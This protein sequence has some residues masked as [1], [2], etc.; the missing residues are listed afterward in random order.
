MNRKKERN[1]ANAYGNVQCRKQDLV[2]CDTRDASV[3]KEQQKKV[4]I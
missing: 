2:L 3:S 1:D 4:I